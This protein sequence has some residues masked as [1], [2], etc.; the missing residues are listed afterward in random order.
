MPDLIFL[1]DVAKVQLSSKRLRQ[2]FRL[3][4]TNALFLAI[5]HFIAK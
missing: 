2:N 3:V 4:D 1:N 5:N